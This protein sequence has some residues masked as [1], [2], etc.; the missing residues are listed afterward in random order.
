MTDPDDLVDRLRHEYARLP[1]D[2]PPPD[3][4][5]LARQS[6]RSRR[7]RRVR[8]AAGALAATVAAVGVA[9]GGGSGSRTATDFA[10]AI[11]TYDGPL[12]ADG[13]YGAA[14]RALDCRY[15]PTG[16]RD[17]STPYES[18]ATRDTPAGAVE[19]AYS[20][21]LFIDA[22]EVDLALAAEDDDRQLLTYEVD[23]RVL[24][25]LLVRDGP[26]T[27]GAGGP[28][29]YVEAFA[30]CDFAE[31]PD[32]LTAT[33]LTRYSVWT[34]VD[35]VRVP[36]SQVFSSPGPEHCDW[37]RM[38]FLY[39]G[40]GRRERTFVEDPEKR[41]RDYVAGPYRAD[42]PL[43]SDATDTGWEREGRH[44]WLSADGDY[45]YVGTADSVAAWPRF[46]TGCE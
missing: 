39:L 16:S 21:G 42:V 14:G 7:R 36:V 2:G 35:G 24:M 22:P 9:V 45:A 17:S 25:A 18:G 6:L 20:E 19:T 38:T 37:Q 44:L 41:L 15:R 28:G 4:A 3:V 11:T 43:P 23:G 10:P 13:P 33:G 30:R 12:D 8:L 46:N 40:S 29:W 32:A 1:A 26:A 27:E 34:D 31:F 5:V